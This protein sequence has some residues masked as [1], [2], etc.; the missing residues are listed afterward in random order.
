MLKFSTKMP[1]SLAE[2]VF[3][4]QLIKVLDFLDHSSFTVHTQHEDR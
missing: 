3:N 1:D 2:I 4:Q